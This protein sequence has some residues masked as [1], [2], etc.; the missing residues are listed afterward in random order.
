MSSPVGDAAVIDALTEVF[1][2]SPTDDDSAAH[3]KA[4]VAPAATPTPLE[5]LERFFRSGGHATPRGGSR[6]VTRSPARR[7]SARGAAAGDVY[8]P[9]FA[10]LA[11]GT[12]GLSPDATPD[13]GV[14]AAPAATLP[15]VVVTPQRRVAGAIAAAAAAAASP[16]LSR[17][18]R[19]KGLARLSLALRRLATLRR[20]HVAL[21]RSG[22]VPHVPA[23]PPP[24]SSP[25]AEASPPRLELT[26]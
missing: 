4:A 9:Q 19:A 21:R 6:M 16:P 10:S 1:G 2:A 8:S 11:R 12:Q 13:V 23:R 24:A 26:V 7:P 25:G 5:R 18:P 3:A 20:L 17:R 15:L 22:S 14:G